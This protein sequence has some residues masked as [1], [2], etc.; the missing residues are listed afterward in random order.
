MQNVVSLNIRILTPS[1]FSYHSAH[2]SGQHLIGIL[3]NV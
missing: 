3:L 2:A 1:F